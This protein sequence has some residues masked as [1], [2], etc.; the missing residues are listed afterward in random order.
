MQVGTEPLERRRP[1]RQERY[2]EPPTR[3]LV[4]TIL[5]TYREMP[6]LILHVRQAARLFGLRETT[7][8][9]VLDEL[10][11]QGSLRRALDGQYL[12]V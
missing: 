4:D 2:D 10:V 5:S 6:G 12:S 1:V 3:H 7:C 11:G 8:Q 9:R